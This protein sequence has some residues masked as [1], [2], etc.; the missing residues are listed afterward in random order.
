MITKVA[1]IMYFLLPLLIWLICWRAVGPPPRVLFL[2]II[3][4]TAANWALAVF[5]WLA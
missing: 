3:L 1:A 5:F 4:A 2:P